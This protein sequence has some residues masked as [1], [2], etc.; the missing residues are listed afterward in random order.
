MFLR[1]TI[2]E[3]ELDTGRQKGIFTLAYEI[4]KEKDVP[5]EQEKLIC[6]LIKWFE[7]NLLIPTKFSKKKNDSHKNTQG[8]SWIK[9]DSTDTI[10]KLWSL[11]SLIE[12]LG[13]SINVIKAQNPGKIVYQDSKQVIALPYGPE[14]KNI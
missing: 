10:T 9:S 3:I 7:K 14:T 4:L 12:E 13:Y 6:D 11:K 2:E 5:K 1:F 8:I